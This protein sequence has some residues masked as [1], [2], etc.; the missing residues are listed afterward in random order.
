MKLKDIK[1]K[2]AGDMVYDR[3]FPSSLKKWRETFKV[4]QTD[5]AK[6]L[7]LSPSVISDY[8]T[9]RRR[10]PGIRTITKIIDAMIEMDI[11]KGSSTINMLSML[12][13]S[14][15]DNGIME[16]IEFEETVSIKEFCDRIDAKILVDRPSRIRGCTIIDSERAIVEMSAED[17]IQFF[18]EFPER[19]FVFT[20]VHS[21]KTAM[22]AVKVG[23][24]YA[25]ML[26]P[27]IIV[28]HKPN[29]VSKMSVKIAE[30]EDIALATTKMELRDIIN[31]LK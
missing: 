3:D 18:G 4:S 17:F 10:S 1:K 16:I 29:K 21:G 27:R 15:K 22:V 8:E 5:L 9:G 19:A 30:T 24:L 7:K 20:N 14:P 2:I 11:S 13:D 23:R 28:L 25:K 12:K 6:H 26:K 31:R